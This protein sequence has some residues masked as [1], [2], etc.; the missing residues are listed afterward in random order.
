MNAL[1]QAIAVRNERRAVLTDIRKR[2]RAATA[3]LLDL[4]RSLEAA[5]RSYESSCGSRELGEP[6]DVVGTKRA[7]ADLLAESETLEGALR[8][9]AGRI[10]IAEADARTA[11]L[12]AIRLEIDDAKREAARIAIET[13][14]LADR[15]AASHAAWHALA[16]KAERL[17]AELPGPRGT[18]PIQF[19]G[20]HGTLSP[21]HGEGG[22]LGRLRA[23]GIDSTFAAIGEKLSLLPLLTSGGASDDDDEDEP[24]DEIGCLTS[25]GA[26]G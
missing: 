1:D 2:E 10:H 22:I 13:L 20:C 8:E 4:D 12:A 19:D 23:H 6:A 24:E 17:A 26:E 21:Q 25:A 3:K 11:E 9:V 14:A 7:Y 15:F 5:K 18:Q 16:R